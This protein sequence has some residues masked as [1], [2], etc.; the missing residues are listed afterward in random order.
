[1]RLWCGVVLARG[2]RVQ[3]VDAL[4]DFD[5]I[6]FPECKPL[7]WA[8]V[9]PNASPQALSLLDRFLVYDPV[10]RISAA[11]VR[12]TQTKY[13]LGVW[14]CGFGCWGG[15]H[16]MCAG[17]RMPTDVAQAL[18]HPYFFTPPPPTHRHSASRRQLHRLS[19]PSTF[20]GDLDLAAPFTIPLS[21][22]VPRDAHLLLPHPSYD[23]HGHSGSGVSSTSSS[24]ANGLASAGAVSA[25]SAPRDAVSSGADGSGG[26]AGTGTGTGAG[27][28]GGRD[29][30]E[31]IHYPLASIPRHRPSPI[32]LQLTSSGFGPQGMAAHGARAGAGVGAGAAAANRTGTAGS[33][34]ASLDTSALDLSLSAASVSSG[35]GSGSGS[36]ARRSDTPTPAASATVT[37]PHR[38]PSASHNTSA[39]GA[40]AGRSPPRLGDWGPIALASASPSDPFSTRD[41]LDVM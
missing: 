41:W 6:Q 18:R 15:T 24:F 13:L 9:L 37:A 25:A 34:S 7:E 23:V 4:P 21:T 28:G 29:G 3:G 40:T 16:S 32:P 20:A 22:C 17:A 27:T 30:V 39:A 14:R 2:V 11:E 36:V 33:E 38:S 10:Q 8:K 26:A 1:M 12:T 5:K 19:K 35:G 31:V